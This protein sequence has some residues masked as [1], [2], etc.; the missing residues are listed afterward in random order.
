MFARNNRNRKAP[1]GTS[2]G[3]AEALRPLFAASPREGTSTMPSNRTVT[4]R[5]KTSVV[6]HEACAVWLIG[7]V[8]MSYALPV[9][10]AGPAPPNSSA[11]WTGFAGA[12]ASALKTA[13]P[14]S[15]L[16][17]GGLLVL[18]QG[19]NISLDGLREFGPKRLR[20]SDLD[21][22]LR[23]DL[24]AAYRL[25]TTQPLLR[26]AF[27]PTT[28]EASGDIFF[29]PAGRSRAQLGVHY[30]DRLQ[31]EPLDVSVFT[32]LE[33]DPARHQRRHT[34]G[35]DIG[36]DALKLHGHLA[37]E[38]RDRP[39]RAPRLRAHEVEAYQLELDGRVP[40]MPWAR[41]RARTFWEAAPTKAGKDREGYRVGLALDP[42]PPLMLE[43]GTDDSN[44]ED[45]DWFARLSVK[46]R[47]N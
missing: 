20:R 41:V 24:S 7:L 31:N 8:A 42:V 40:A 46:L 2:P 43:T 22:T 21:I 1:A 39:P 16:V 37:R 32:G 4:P 17:A 34:L 30:A 35:G 18:E 29:D 11:S 38:T 9:H 23:D 12:A 5:R 19:I 15:D 26:S 25:R 44:L 3:N 45:S 27:G 28:L 14:Q 33:V 10:A 36:W 47:F 6:L 13:G